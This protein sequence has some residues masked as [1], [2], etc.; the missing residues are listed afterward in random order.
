MN[1]LQIFKSS[2]FGEVRTCTVNEEPMFCLSDICRVL[3]IKNVSDC[4]NRLWKK[5]IVT[6][7]TLTK[8][9]IQKMIFVNESNLYKIIFQ[10]RKESAERFTDWVT[11]EVLPSIR[12]HGMYATDELINNPD[13]LI[14]VATQL[15]VEREKNNL[16]EQKIE[17]DR[18]KTVFAD[19]VS[20]SKQSIL[21][22]DLA[23][24]IC[25]NGHPIGQKRLFQW[26]R[27]N[28]YLIKN[29]SSYNMPMQ[30]YV[31]QGLFEVK[32]STINNPDGSVRLTRTTKIT[33]RGQIYFINKFLK[34]KK[35]NE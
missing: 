13:L 20:S 9:G 19:S 10:S 3:D 5:G 11:S 2:E 24:L 14:A 6:A 31:E 12:K 26:M 22:G 32:E 4:K 27:D 29:G 7:D 1:D 16:L 28:G 21:V 35:Y 15:K 34:E 18:P 33:G 25:Q 23:K 8:G 17:Q 30:R